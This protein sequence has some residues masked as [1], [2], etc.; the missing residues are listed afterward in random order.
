MVESWEFLSL[1]G[2]IGEKEQ[3]NGEFNQVKPISQVSAIAKLDS[4]CV[5]QMLMTVWVTSVDN[6]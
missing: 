5:S 1:S 2:L 4:I 3:K 6:P